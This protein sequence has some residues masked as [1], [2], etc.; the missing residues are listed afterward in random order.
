MKVIDSIKKKVR[1]SVKNLVGI[2]KQFV[3][4][5]D[6]ANA[7]GN[8]LSALD[9]AKNEAVTKLL[10]EPTVKNFDLAIEAELRRTAAGAIYQTVGGAIGGPQAAELEASD[11]TVKTLLEACETYAQELTANIEQIRADAHALA[12]RCGIDFV[13]PPAIQVMQSEL[14]SANAAAEACRDRLNGGNYPDL[15][16]RISPMLRAA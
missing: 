2:E 3:A 6:T 16:R 7:I 15:W 1:G 12:D 4:I 10:A 9:R 8:H 5:R 11:E 14:D 13:E